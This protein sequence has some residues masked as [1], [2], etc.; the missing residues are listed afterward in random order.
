MQYDRK[1]QEPIPLRQTTQQQLPM[2]RHPVVNLAQS[3]ESTAKSRHP[4]KSS[5]GDWTD[6]D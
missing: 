1:Q 5:W 3:R 2:I 6:G 4:C